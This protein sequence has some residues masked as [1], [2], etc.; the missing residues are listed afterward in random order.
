MPDNPVTSMGSP[1]LPRF[2]QA[3]IFPADM[4]IL[5]LWWTAISQGRISLTY[6]QSAVTRREKIESDMAATT[7]D[8]LPFGSE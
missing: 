8:D 6:V 7:S 5:G 1:C 2:S 3:R 4:P